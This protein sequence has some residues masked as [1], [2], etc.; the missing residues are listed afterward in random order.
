MNFP[1][2][3]AAVLKGNIPDLISMYDAK[4]NGPVIAAFSLSLSFKLFP[5]KYRKVQIS[6][7]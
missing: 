3:E 7:F 1:G 6:I 2:S 5:F 4:V